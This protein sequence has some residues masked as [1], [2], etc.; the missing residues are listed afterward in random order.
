ME[1]ATVPPHYSVST[2]QL[3]KD[4]PR[5]YSISLTMADGPDESRSLDNAE[6]RTNQEYKTTKNNQIYIA[7]YCKSL[8]PCPDRSAFRNLESGRTMPRRNTGIQETCLNVEGIEGTNE[9]MRHSVRRGS[10]SYDTAMPQSCDGSEC[11]PYAITRMSR[12]RQLDATDGAQRN[13]AIITNPLNKSCRCKVMPDI[14][15]RRNC[16]YVSAM[17]QA[18]DKRENIFVSRTRGSSL[19]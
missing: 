2:G 6:A 16:L 13:R 11:V 5:S 10:G 1:M 9:D 14:H 8:P 18:T 17:S 19:V 4:V 15:W 12:P 3:D 7:R